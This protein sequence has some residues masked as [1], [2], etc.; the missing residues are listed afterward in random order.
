[1]RGIRKSFPPFPSQTLKLS[2]PSNVSTP[3]GTQGANSLEIIQ[4][5]FKSRA[6]RQSLRY[7]TLT[8]HS[9]NLG[10]FRGCRSLPLVLPDALSGPCGTRATLKISVTREGEREEFICWLHLLTLV[11]TGALR[12]GSLSIWA[13]SL[14]LKQNKSSMPLARGRAVLPLPP[15]QRVG[16][17]LVP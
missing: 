5:S 8:Q 16:E 6:L 15:S 4:D 9:R 13:W 11:K 2:P 3:W 10:K 14:A 1:M 12:V 7:K 17:V